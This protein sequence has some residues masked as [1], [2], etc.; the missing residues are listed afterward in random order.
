MTDLPLT[1][2][3]CGP[4]GRRT[5]ERFYDLV[6]A[7]MPDKVIHAA[8]G[9]RF[10]FEA[11]GNTNR[12]LV[13]NS[14]PTVAAQRGG[15]ARVRRTQLGTSAFFHRSGGLRRKLRF[16]ANPITRRGVFWEAVSPKSPRV[17]GSPIFTSDFR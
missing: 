17:R 5:G 2:N 6:R 15:V 16:A 3:R 13:D 12:R 10:V 1:A 14:G 7:E 11:C 9:A 8:V 4:R